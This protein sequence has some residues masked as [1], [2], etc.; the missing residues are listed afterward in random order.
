MYACLSASSC[1]EGQTAGI[2]VDEF[3]R[4]EGGADSRGARPLRWPWVARWVY[5]SVQD[6]LSVVRS[7]LQTEIASWRI[8]Y[9][10]LLDKYHALKLSGASV[11]EPTPTLL[12]PA[13]DPVLAAITAKAGPD[14]KLRA[15]MSREAIQSRAA[16]VPD[17]EIIQAIE[18]GVTVDEE[19]V[20]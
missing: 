9:E 17:I 6:D 5:D 2:S 20:A 14:R 11:P 3:R 7:D 4:S 15:M 12:I 18:Q 8:R 13:F 1:V 10:A 19:G 16:G